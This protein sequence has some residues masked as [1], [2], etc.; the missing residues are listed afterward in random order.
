MQS[1]VFQGILRISDVLHVDGVDRE[2]SHTA[3]SLTDRN[4]SHSCDY[5]LCIILIIMFFFLCVS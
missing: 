4:K 1:A 2:K 3:R 5:F